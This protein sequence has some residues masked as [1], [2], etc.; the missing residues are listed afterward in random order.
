MNNRCGVHLSELRAFCARPKEHKGDH[1][2]FPD[3][4][5]VLPHSALSRV[6]NRI[7]SELE[8]L[9][10]LRA[11][12]SQY[13]GRRRVLCMGSTPGAINGCGGAL[14]VK[15]LTYIQTL[16]YTSPYSCSGGDYWN[17]G[18]GQFVCTACGALNRL[19]ERP[20]VVELKSFFKE[21][22]EKKT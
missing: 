2:K 3:N 12:E 4:Q 15:D 16:W 1:S 7:K 8:L 21:M 5:G 20:Q 19:Y 11:L 9:V 17:N 13:L 18:E 6:R 14:F 22:V 10:A